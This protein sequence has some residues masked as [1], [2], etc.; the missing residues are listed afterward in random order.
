[1]QQKVSTA[2]RKPPILVIGA[3]LGRTGTMS[4]KSALEHI[5]GEP[6]Y[7]MFELLSQHRDHAQKWL[8][9]DKL[10]SQSP[11]GH[12]EGSLFDEIFKG[13]RCTVDYPACT[14]YAQLMEH[15]P[16]AKVILTVRETTKWLDSVRHTI[17]KKRTFSWMNW[18]EEFLQFG[19]ATVQMFDCEIKR[20]LG[21]TVDRYSDKECA[22]AFEKWNQRVQRYVPAERL[23]VFRVTDGWEPLCQFLQVPVPTIPFPH[24]NN[25][26]EFHSNV[27]FHM[28]QHRIQ[29]LLFLAMGLVCY[30][31]FK[32]FQMLSAR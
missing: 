11:D 14:Y 9:V 7:H 17:L 2:V 26:E 5:Y 12:I 15:Y 10:V 30:I 23:L 6:C 25:R 3:G 31:V 24:K 29:I 1:M 27:N 13:Y 32:G 20:S 21:Y 18:L 28:D 16:D 22:A 19:A 8:Q 4:L